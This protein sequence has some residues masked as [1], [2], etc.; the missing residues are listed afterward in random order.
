MSIFINN[1]T[2]G[3]R[4]WAE[5]HSPKI[6]DEACT[7]AGENGVTVVAD[8]N[9]GGKTLDRQPHCPWLVPGTGRL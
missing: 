9:P 1:R 5:V 8:V 3:F 6:V 2:S 7:G 4:K